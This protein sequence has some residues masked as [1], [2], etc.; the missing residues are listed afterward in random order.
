MASDALRKSVAE[1]IGTFALVFIG[2]GAIIVTGGSDLLAIAFAHGLTIGVMVSAMAH[3]SGGHFNSTVTLGALVGRQ[4]PA[5]LAVVYW[6]AQL[7]GAVAGIVYSRLFLE[8]STYWM[9]T[10]G[11]SKSPLIEVRSLP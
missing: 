5:R 10:F 2:A 1:F 9:S 3:V 8:R 4:I 11:R 7:G 6:V